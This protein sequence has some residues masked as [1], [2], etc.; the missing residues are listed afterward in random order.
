M[1]KRALLAGTL[2]MAYW[3]G[4]FPVHAQSQQPSIG[5][6]SAWPLVANVGTVQVTVSVAISPDGSVIQSPIDLLEVDGNGNA[7]T[8]LGPLNDDGLDGDAVAGDFIYSGTFELSS[9]NPGLIGLEVAVPV[10]GSSRLTLSP[11]YFFEFLPSGAP[12]AVLASD[13]SCTVTDPSSGTEY[14][15]DQ[16]LAMA[17]PGTAYSRILS[18]ASYLQGSIIGIVPGSTM[19]TWQI[20]VGCQSNYTTLA[21]LADSINTPELAWDS[22]LNA[23]ADDIGYRPNDP[24]WSDPAQYSMRIIQADRAWTITRGA[25]GNS[26]PLIA[27]IDSGLLFTHPEFAGRATLGKD[28]VCEFDTCN[29]KDYSGHGTKV[30]GII[31]AAGD[32][33]IGIAG[34][35]WKC[36]LLIFKTQ[37]SSGKGDDAT[38]AAAVLEAVGKSASIVNISSGSV[39]R[40]ETMCKAIFDAEKKG[41]MVV[42]GAGNSGNSTPFYP[43]AYKGNETFGKWFPTTYFC[44]AVAVGATDSSDA[45][46]NKSNYGTWVDLYAPGVDVATT[47]QN[48]TGGYTAVTGTSFAA[49][50]VAGVLGLLKSVTPSATSGT[51]L[52]ALLTIMD[53]TANLDPA[54]KRIFRVNAFKPAFYLAATSNGEGAVFQDIVGASA[55]TGVPIT[56]G[57]AKRGRN[58]TQPIDVHGVSLPL[59]PTPTSYTIQVSYSLS[60]YDAYVNQLYYDSFSVTTSAK[61][62]WNLTL[63]PNTA[64][65]LA[66]P[67]NPLSVGFLWGG[68][69]RGPES[70]LTTT[71]N[72]VDVTVAGGANNT[73]LNLVLD[74][75]TFSKADTNFPSSGTFTVL[76]ITPK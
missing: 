16:V 18:I 46:W 61:P 57:V 8:N 67:P 71:A 58:D 55:A 64:L 42:A 32:N 36:Q 41:L 65:N 37:R 30:A 70:P 38:Q 48:G 23:I 13:Q 49:P 5:Q 52:D 24:K 12:T 39:A 6:P 45:I 76:D 60:T 51:L 15:A 75:K 62:Y 10:Q 68:Q 35:C 56:L 44:S 7:I 33:N 29:G 72:A 26:G 2:T 31:G 9:E 69:Q 22:E 11:V 1:I 14:V 19:D 3:F 50:H 47:T 53:T 28:Y 43:A 25:I 54:G 34:V 27:I 59:L 73:I 4:S 74:T 66:S 63:N 20:Q 17:P 21:A 40:S